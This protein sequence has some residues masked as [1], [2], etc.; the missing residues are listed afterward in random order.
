MAATIVLGS[1]WGD[2]GKGKVCVYFH[3]FR[4]M[5]CLIT[6]TRVSAI[7]FILSLQISR[8]FRIE[9]DLLRS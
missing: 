7:Q 2:E 4:D 1:S 5:E 9:I 6:C 3:F 8:A